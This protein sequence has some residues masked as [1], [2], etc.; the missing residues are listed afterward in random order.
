MKDR[1]IS[2]IK[3]YRDVIPYVIF[4]VLTTVLNVVSYL[5]F[6]HLL[7]FS[8]IVSTILAW[9]VAV[10]FAYLTN[11]KWVFFS[12]AKSKKEIINEIISFFYCRLG[13]GVVDV[14][15]MWFFVDQLHFQD[16]WVKVFA[17][18]VVIVLNYVASKWLIFKH[19]KKGKLVNK[20]LVV[21][22]SVLAFIVLIAAILYIGIF[23]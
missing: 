22:A 8:T 21:W 17:N 7:N 6:A 13:T 23:W 16:G 19:G 2:L 3:K 1:L 5:L 4:G 12:D 15:I 20:K 9:L 11:R 18:I 10:I 14:L